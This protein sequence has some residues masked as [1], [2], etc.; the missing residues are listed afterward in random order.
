M[1][2]LVLATGSTAASAQVDVSLGTDPTTAS[3]L[4]GPLV[5]VDGEAREW[6][7]VVA[8]TSVDNIEVVGRAILDDLSTRGFWF[9]SLDSVVTTTD[10]R[11]RYF[12]SSGPPVRISDVVARGLIKLD[13]KAEI[14]LFESQAGGVFDQTVLERDIRELLLRYADSG[15]PLATAVYRVKRV[16][17]FGPDPRV[18]VDLVVD[19]GTNV[20]LSEV[21]LAS[22]IRTRGKLL[23]RLAGLRVGREVRRFDPDEI[24][25]SLESTGLFSSV[26]EVRL[27][28][29]ARGRGTL[30][31]PLVENP[32]GSF[33]LVL[34]YLS[35]PR[36]GGSV[37]GNGHI[38]LRN[39]FGGARVFSMR[40]DR[41]S[42]RVSTL[43]AMVE[44]PYVF[45]SSLGVAALFRGEQRDSTYA[46]QSYAV[47]LQYKVADGL[48][49]TVGARRDVTRPG[50]SGLTIANGRQ[51]IPRS[52]TFFGGLG[53]RY[54]KVDSPMNPRRGVE[55]SSGFQRGTKQITT[56]RV[57]GADTLLQAEGLAQERL[58]VVA[59]V[60]V[61]LSRRQ[62]FAAGGEAEAL[63]SS[64]YDEADLVRLGGAKSL[65]GY[66]EEQFA[67]RF[68]A[69]GFVEYRMLLDRLSYVFAF[70]DLG[71][72]ESVALA[73]PGDS[74]TNAYPGFG[75][76]IQFDTSI[77]LMNATYG[78][79]A[80]D[81]PLNGKVHVG[82]SFAL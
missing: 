30:T 14:R 76:G 66:N 23:A 48:F 50:Q 53:I 43:D 27:E 28:A 29:D 44:D 40:L 39:V 13:A 34:G 17:Q 42:G 20:E 24:R 21:Q 45:G 15:W 35:N 63:L 73:A 81:G 37:V 2:V 32:P 1:V 61:P 9:A 22:D 46:K 80:D 77:G 16:P 57:A 79:N 67:G 68:V 75:V 82:L 49:L 55:A 58:H 18:E 5:F 4:A 36:G 31:I 51:R 26:G 64:E 70:A 52:S 6:L 10:R 54:S 60:Y 72:V 12:V 38:I 78:M 65:R 7:P 71:Y 56:F 62:V 59:R 74:R 25:R 41:L 47:D 3:R 33:D 8:L 11:S 19:E 69:R